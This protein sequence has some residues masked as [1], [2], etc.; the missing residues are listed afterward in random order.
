VKSKLPIDGPKTLNGLILETLES[1]PEPGTGLRIAGYTIEVVQATGQSV[2]TA[3][4]IPDRTA[5]TGEP[6]PAGGTGRQPE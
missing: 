3:R 4:L 5:T 2:K 6:Q 1:M